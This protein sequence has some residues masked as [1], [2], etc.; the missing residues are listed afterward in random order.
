VTF[1]KKKIKM[2]IPFRIFEKFS[3]KVQTEALTRQDNF[4]RVPADTVLVYKLFVF[5]SG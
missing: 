1:L 3:P 4:N 5:H 2:I